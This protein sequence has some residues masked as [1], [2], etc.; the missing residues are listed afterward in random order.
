MKHFL[1]AMTFLA[2]MGCLTPANAQTPDNSSISIRFDKRGTLLLQND[3][4]TESISGKLTT[5]EKKI[6]ESKGISVTQ[7]DDLLKDLFEGKIQI[8]EK[9]NIKNEFFLTSPISKNGIARLINCDPRFCDRPTLIS[10]AEKPS[11]KAKQLCNQKNC[12]PKEISTIGTFKMDSAMLMDKAKNPSPPPKPP[13]DPDTCL[14]ECND[15][16]VETYECDS[17]SKKGCFKQKA[18]TNKCI[19]KC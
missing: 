13:K 19:K 3:V 5:R 4:A 7:T 15:T 2:I 1:A 11:L 17:D 12:D 16:C 9:Q 6:F 14:A 10:P 8:I 18:C